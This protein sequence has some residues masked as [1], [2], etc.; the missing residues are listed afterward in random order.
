MSKAEIKNSIIKIMR[1]NLSEDMF[2]NKEI[3]FMIKKNAGIINLC[4][5][6]YIKDFGMHDV[7]AKLLENYISEYFH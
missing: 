6:E 2:S 1:E 7:N 3:D 4:A 5:D